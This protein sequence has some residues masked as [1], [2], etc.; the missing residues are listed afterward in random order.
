LPVMT[1]F[2]KGSMQFVAMKYGPNHQLY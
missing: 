2:K 1:F